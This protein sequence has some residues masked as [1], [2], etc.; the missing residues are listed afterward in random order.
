MISERLLSKT[1]HVYYSNFCFGIM[2]CYK[3][4]RLVHSYLL[5]CCCHPKSLCFTS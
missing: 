2:V 3:Y 1:L 4:R 5:N